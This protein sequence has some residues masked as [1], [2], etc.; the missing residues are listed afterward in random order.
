LLL[1][2]KLGFIMT[3]APKI[4]LLYVPTDELLKFAVMG[5]NDD[6]AQSEAR[7]RFTGIFRSRASV[8]PQ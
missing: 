7:C 4:S 3:A 1:D 2:T 8:R 6:L 5:I